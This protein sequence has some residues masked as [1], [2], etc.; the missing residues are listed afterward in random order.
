[1]TALLPPRFLFRYAFPVRRVDRLPRRGGRLL[2]LPSSCTLPLPAGFEG[3]GDFAQLRCA[4]NPNGLGI[5]VVVKGRSAPLVIDP[6]E[7]GA[8]DGLRVWIDTRNTQSIHRASRYC[9]EFELLPAG[10]GEDGT[11]ALPIPRPIARAKEDA[12]LC[13]P[14]L[15]P[16]Q[17]EVSRT[18]YRLDAWLPAAALQGYDPSSHP[19]LGFYFAVQDAELGL[20]T[21]SVGPEFPFASDPSL[22]STLELIDG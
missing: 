16:V 19:Y 10:A 22:W 9:H 17:S 13:D 20:Q 8:S 18:G 6:A 21:L 3:E 5:S 1:M 4:W 15:L 2:H 12:P 7:P 14:D 11:A